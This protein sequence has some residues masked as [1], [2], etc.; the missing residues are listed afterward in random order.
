M[1][2]APSTSCALGAKVAMHF[3]FAQFRLP[4]LRRL[5][6]SVNLFVIELFLVLNVPYQISHLSLLFF[7]FLLGIFYFLDCFHLFIKDYANVFSF[8]N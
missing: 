1:F 8:I 6:Y 2:F 3:Y 4:T 7:D 5:T